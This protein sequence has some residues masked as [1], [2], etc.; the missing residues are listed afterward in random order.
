MGVDVH[1]LT[2]V[3]VTVTSSSE[4]QEW[5][6]LLKPRRFALIVFKMNFLCLTHYM[7]GGLTDL[8]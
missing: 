8:S 4:K 2:L 3:D 7:V 5:L 1:P 6:G